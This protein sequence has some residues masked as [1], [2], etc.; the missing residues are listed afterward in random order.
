MLILVVEVQRLPVEEPVEFD[1]VLL[2]VELRIATAV[3]ALSALECDVLFCRLVSVEEFRGSLSHLVEFIDH[4]LLESRQALKSLAFQP[5]YKV[6]LL[7]QQIPQPA[8][9]LTSGRRHALA[10][11]YVIIIRGGGGGLIVGFRP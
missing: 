2:V 5:G 9:V 3:R 8:V 10:I 11:C 6:C 4:L 7:K 1:A